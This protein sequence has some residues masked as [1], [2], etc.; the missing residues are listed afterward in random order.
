MKIKILFVSLSF[1]LSENYILTKLEGADFSEEQNKVLAAMSQEALKNTGMKSMSELSEFIPKLKLIKINEDSQDDV[2]TKLGNPSNKNLLFGTNVWRYIFFGDN[3][4]SV[5]CSIEFDSNQNVTYVDVVNGGMS[6]MEMI[7]NQGVSRLG[8]NPVTASQ[9]Q[10]A[11]IPQAPQAVT[12]P[13]APTEGQ[14]YFNTTDKHFYG[15]N[16]SNWKQLD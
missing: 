13:E 15:W 11:G 8:P 9:P 16:G 10:G 1:F 14:I 2:I 7:Y 6:G 5:T 4:N 3:A 12:A